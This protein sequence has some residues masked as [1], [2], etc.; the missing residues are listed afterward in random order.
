MQCYHEWRLHH[1]RLFSKN[2]SYLLM[3]VGIITHTSSTKWI[4]K[5]VL[6]C[7]HYFF[8]FNFKSLNSKQIILFYYTY[9]IDLTLFYAYT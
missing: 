1:Y 5:R 9:F 8:V 6:E 4:N 7:I 2:M 3:R